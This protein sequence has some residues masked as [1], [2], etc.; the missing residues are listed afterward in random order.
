MRE[1]KSVVI[2]IMVLFLVFGLCSG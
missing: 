2:L 1:K